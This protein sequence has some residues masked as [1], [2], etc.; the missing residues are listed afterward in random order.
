MKLLL[1]THAFLWFIMGS[2]NLSVKARAA[3]E[4]LANEKHVSAASVWEMAIKVSAGKLSLSAPF[5]TLIPTNSTRMGLKC[6]PS[7]WPMLPR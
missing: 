7:K 6:C 1:D 5:S 4:D 2:P 3:I